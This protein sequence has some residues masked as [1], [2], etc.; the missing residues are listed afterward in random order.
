MMNVSLHTQ[1]YNTLLYE[2]CIKFNSHTSRP[3][4]IASEPQLFLQLIC[5]CTSTLHAGGRSHHKEEYLYRLCPNNNGHTE[6]LSN[7][8]TALPFASLPSLP[9]LPNSCTSSSREGGHPTRMTW[10]TLGTSTPIPNAV[11]HTIIWIVESSG[12]QLSTAL[13]LS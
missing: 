1:L 9:A 5:P 3:F 2:A 7:Q 10:S 12:H 8:L 6:S 11:V 13:S 4:E